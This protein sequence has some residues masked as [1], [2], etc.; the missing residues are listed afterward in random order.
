VEVVQ[1]ERV[2]EVLIAIPSAQ[3]E[4]IRRLVGLCARART[5]SRIVPGLIEIIRGDVQFQQ[6]RAV[7]P[8]D[9]LGRQVEVPAENRAQDA[10]PADKALAQV[11]K[12]KSRSA[13]L[14]IGRKRL[15]ERL[16]ARFRH[17]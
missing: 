9:L 13:L 12:V 4:V 2:D 10:A 11:W 6:I 15:L 16:D 5:G 1:N 3:G 7:R 17:I 8:E 14:L